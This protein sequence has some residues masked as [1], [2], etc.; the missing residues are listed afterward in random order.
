MGYNVRIG[1]S[2]HASKRM[3]ML[4]RQPDPMHENASAGPENRRFFR[5]FCRR[6]EKLTGRTARAEAADNRGTARR[7]TMGQ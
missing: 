5:T 4:Q 1:K 6:R 2:E 7:F 3:Q